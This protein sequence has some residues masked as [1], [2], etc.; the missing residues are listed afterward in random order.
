MNN[1]IKSA[2]FIR[3]LHYG[4]QRKFSDFLDPQESWKDVLVSNPQGYL[5]PTGE[6]KYSQVLAFKVMCWSSTV[7]H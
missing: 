1:T 7:L 6:P 5:K 3:N 4:V 2:T